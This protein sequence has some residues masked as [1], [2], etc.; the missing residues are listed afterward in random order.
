MVAQLQLFD[1]KVYDIRPFLK[2]RYKYPHFL[3]VYSVYA[4]DQK[5]YKKLYF[6]IWKKATEDDDASIYD[7]VS[8]YELLSKC[9]LKDK[10]GEKKHLG[11]E[12]HIYRYKT[13]YKIYER[14]GDV[15]FNGQRKLELEI[16]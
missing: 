1:A 10:K 2:K 15:L 5:K 16:E 14:L 6:P 7:T 4:Y 12:K 11:D 13:L 9:I 3:K 8:P